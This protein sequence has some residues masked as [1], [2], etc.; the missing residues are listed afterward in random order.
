MT[1]ETLVEELRSLS[2]QDFLAF[3]LNEIAYIRQLADEA[4]GVVGIFAADGT[5]IG[6]MARA[7]VAI[8]AVRQ[9]DMEP[10]SLH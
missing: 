3:G 4:P 7:E 10:L 8:A 1:N 5:Q 2:Q 9:N 6:S